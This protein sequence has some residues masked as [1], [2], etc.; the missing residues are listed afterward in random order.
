LVHSNDTSQ[1]PR[2]QDTTNSI[3]QRRMNYLELHI[4]SLHSLSLA[5]AHRISANQDGALRHDG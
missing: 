5:T 4:L 2:L 1:Q 3:S